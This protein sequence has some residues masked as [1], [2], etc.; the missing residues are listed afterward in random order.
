MK[1]QMKDKGKGKVGEGSTTK[2]KSPS[3]QPPSPKPMSPKQPPP[4]SS[5]TSRLI[6]S[7]NVQTKILSWNDLIKEELGIWL[8]PKAKVAFEEAKLRD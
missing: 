6:S 3:L 7:S 8:S 2:E 5:Q 4:E 1:E